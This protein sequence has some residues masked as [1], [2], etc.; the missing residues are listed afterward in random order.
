VLGCYSVRE[1]LVTDS[2]PPGCIN[3]TPAFGFR[4]R[5]TYQIPLEHHDLSGEVA[6]HVEKSRGCFFSFSFAQ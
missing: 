1:S 2:Q 4:K 5:L 6:W 3:D